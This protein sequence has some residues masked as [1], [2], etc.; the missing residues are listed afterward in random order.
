MTRPEGTEWLDT[1]IAAARAGGEVLRAHHG[2][3]RPGSVTAKGLHDYVTDVDRRSQ[4]KILALL[5]E[6]F[7]GVPVLAEEAPGTDRP[8]GEAGPRW[9]VDPLDGTT[10]FIHGFPCFAV[11]VAL[12]MDGRPAAGAV[13]DPLRDE[14]Y[15]GA[16]G[17]GARLR[18]ERLSVSTTSDLDA[19]LVATGFPFR[20]PERLSAYL[21]CLGEVL[22]RTSGVRRAGS[23]ALDLCAVA[24]GRVDAF[25]EEGLSRW[26]VSAGTVIVEEAGG[27]VTGFTGEAGEHLATGEVVASNGPLH[28]PLLEIVR[29]HLVRG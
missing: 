24:A 20:R 7:P 2:R 3:L 17:L 15:D 6:R 27:R 10:N 18:G 4:E 9:V 28:A 22:R 12:E 16:L 14:L 25:W 29:R 26:D 1:A 13:L 23:A 21:P 19:A 8:A 11:S 5:E